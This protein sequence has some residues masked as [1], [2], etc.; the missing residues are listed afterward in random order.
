MA[1]VLPSQN[2][3]VSISGLGRSLLQAGRLTVEKADTLSK[4]AAAE[5]IPFIDVLLESGLLD[6][7]AVAVFCAETFGYPLLDFSTFNVQVLPDK[8]IDPK[9][10]QSLRVVTLA[11]RGNRLSVAG[12]DSETAQACLRWRRVLPETVTRDHL[13]QLVRPFPERATANKS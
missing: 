5:K 8:I 2:S 3:A 6:A 12:A 4:K 10:M 7:R 9:L 11:K 13:L 1:A